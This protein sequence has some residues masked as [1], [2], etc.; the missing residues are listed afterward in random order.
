MTH[1]NTKAMPINDK[2]LPYKSCRS[3][4]ANHIGSILHHITPLVINSLRGGDTHTHA[5]ACIHTDTHKYTYNQQSNF[6]N[7][8]HTVL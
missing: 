1:I 6:K 2:Q 8:A 5:H 4:L 7:Q 3:C